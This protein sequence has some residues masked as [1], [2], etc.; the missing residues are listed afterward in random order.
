MKAPAH[1]LG[2]NSVA[3]T[4]PARG[5]PQKPAQSQR[6]C[7]WS[8][9]PVSTCRS[10]GRCTAAHQ[11]GARS[12]PAASSQIHTL[13]GKQPPR[14]RFS[15]RSWPQALEGTRTTEALHEKLQC[16][17][18]LLSFPEQRHVLRGEENPSCTQR[19]RHA[20]K[21]GPGLCSTNER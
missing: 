4:F 14:W 13:N 10:L 8:R 1:S 2:G 18:L 9:V 6:S 20:M 15:D 11:A 16:S 17:T 19:V 7:C 21:K 3:G 12:R 5:F